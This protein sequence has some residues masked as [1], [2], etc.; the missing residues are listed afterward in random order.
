[1]GSSRLPFRYHKSYCDGHHNELNYWT[2]D[3]RSERADTELADRLSLLLITHP[4]SVIWA[5]TPPVSRSI[6]ELE[7]KGVKEDALV[8]LK[9]LPS[10]THYFRAM[11]K[12]LPEYT[13][14]V[15]EK[16][17]EGLLVGEKAVIWLL[18]RASV[19]IMANA[20]EEACSAKDVVSRLRATNCRL[21]ATHGEADIKARTDLAAEFRE[22][23][24]SGIIMATMD[25]MPES[26]SLFGATTQHYPQPHY[27]SGP[28]EQSGARPL[29]KDTAK[30]HNFYYVPKGT[31]IEKM[32]AILLPRLET[33]AKLGKSK[34]A[35]A[36]AKLFEKKSESWEDF[37][38]RITAH[39][40]EDGE[41]VF[42]SELCVD[43]SP[44]GEPVESD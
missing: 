30:L 34:D 12:L 11:E 24:G 22:H 41:A 21:W 36:T 31:I 44:E 5:N 37:L 39:G 18:T 7:L 1:M 25:S 10:E 23:N 9:K 16:V 8:T 33:A 32:V 17:M 15:M 3:G 38:A 27:L 42:G 43:E 13:D 2:A 6:I 28:M 20:A 35:E 14:D 19:D 26:I 40:P 4:R 29:L